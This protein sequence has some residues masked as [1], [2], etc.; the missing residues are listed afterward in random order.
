MRHVFLKHDMPLVSIAIN[1]FNYAAY[2]GQCIDSA[3]AQTYRPIEVVVVDDGSTDG[4]RTVIERYADRIRTLFK[5]NGGQASAM[6]AGFA[7][8]SGNVGLFIVADDLL[9]V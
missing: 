3:L 2:V 6:N 4:S 8:A 7:M 5:P 1:N 9:Y